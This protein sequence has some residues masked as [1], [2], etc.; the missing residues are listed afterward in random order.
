MWRR[1][2]RIG[3][4]LPA[5]A[6]VE[7]PWGATVKVHT[8]ENIGSEIYHFGIFD[9]IVPE[10]ICRLLSPG[11]LAIEVGANIGQNCSLMAARTGRRGR[12]L[13][14]EP[15]P[16]IFHELRANH[17]RWPHA[18]FASVQL[19]RVALGKTSGQTTLAMTDEFATN[20]GSAS[21]QDGPINGAGFT[22]EVRRLDEYLDKETVGVCKIDVEGHELAVLEGAEQA[23]HGHRIRDVVFEDFNSKPSPVTEIL[24][25]QGYK[26]FELHYSWLKPRLVPM[27][28]GTPAKGFSFNYLATLD[29]PRAQACFRSPGWRCLRKL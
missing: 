14:F 11:E 29:V 8:G 28:S 16:E 20:R 19:E 23:L 25:G 18:R 12:V 15:H 17:E 13:A 21:L 5:L 3:H 10:T 26:I 22:V 6:D 7:L 9:K 1:L 27:E 2:Q 4:P 24:R